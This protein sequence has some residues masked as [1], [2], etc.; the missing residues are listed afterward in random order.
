MMN[1]IKLIAVAIA[2]LLTVIVVLQNT[3]TVETKLLFFT[4]SMPRAALLF[5]AIAVGFTVGVL[6]ANRIAA[7]NG[8]ETGR[9]DDH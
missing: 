7:R 8:G 1:R 6:V 2:A 5:G 3:E 9:Q 4:L